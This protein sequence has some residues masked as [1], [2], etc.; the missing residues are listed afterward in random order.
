MSFIEID[1]VS[2]SYKKTGFNLYIESLKL[3]QDEITHIC[4]R[5]GS[6]KTTLARLVMGILKPDSGTVF[7]DNINIAKQTLAQ[8]ARKI[9]FL[10]QNPARQL[11]CNTVLDEVM[12]SLKGQNAKDEAMRWLVAFGLEDKCGAHPLTLSVG[13][14]QRLAL[15]C[16]LA[17]KPKY[18]ILDE[19]TSSL[20]TESRNI[21]ISLIK[22]LKDKGIGMSIITHDDALETLRDRSIAIE[23]GRVKYEA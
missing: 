1:G 17:I 18:L 3:E 15:A 11:F 5:N 23:N 7:V 8:N 9:G 6:G 2:F 20:D 21:L 19:P 14:K 16:V 10:F 12:F 4:G 13:E 22:A